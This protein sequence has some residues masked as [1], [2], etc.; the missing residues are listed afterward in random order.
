[1]KLSIPVSKICWR[2]NAGDACRCAAGHGSALAL[3]E[4]A[5]GAGPLAHIIS[6]G[7]R[8][9]DLEQNLAFYRA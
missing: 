8:I 6:D 2:A 1:M 9:A 7:Q 3:A 4:I 5:R